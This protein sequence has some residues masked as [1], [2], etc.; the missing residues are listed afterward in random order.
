MNTLI[1]LLAGAAAFA[2]GFC[3]GLA[4]RP[5]AP[6]RKKTTVRVSD[7]RMREYRN[8]LTYDGREQE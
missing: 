3:A 5:A 6:A 4:R 1:C 7:E 8:F 2:L